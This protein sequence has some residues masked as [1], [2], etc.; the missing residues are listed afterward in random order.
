M[1]I[2]IYSG[3]VPGTTFIERLIKGLASKGQNVLLFGIKRRTVSYS[4]SVSVIGYKANRFSKSLHF[5]KY[6]LLLLLFK[7]KEKHIL[8]AL[9]RSQNRNTLN[10]KL[11][12]YPVLYHQ[13]D[14]FHVQWAKGLDD[15]MWVQDFGMKLVVSLRGAHINYSPIVDLELAAMYRQNFPKVDGFHAVSKTIG[16]EAQ[17]YRAAPEKIQV[18][19]SGLPKL[20]RNL[21]L[22]NFNKT[23]QLISV[24][25][26]HWIKGYS[27]ALDACKLLQTTG[28]SFKYTIIGG[29]DA[30]ELLYQV[31]D[32]GL[33]DVVNLVDNQ[34][35]KM[36]ECY[37]QD[38]DLLLLPSVE[39]GIANVVLEAMAI[40][41]LVLSTNCGGMSEVIVHNKNGF[42]IPIRDSKS[43][44]ETILHIASLSPETCLGI[45]EKAQETILEQHLEPHMVSGMLSLY[46][47]V[48]KG[49][50]RKGK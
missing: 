35:F 32:L 7:N 23:F 26:P 4:Q 28:F 21:S 27:Y 8:D 44:S 20:S 16:Q 3:E 46:E 38:A 14:V 45:R 11:K 15:W 24:G 50:T 37:M 48:V 31:Y 1:R 41:A 2:A 43:M 13:P 47:Q 30:M 6:N 22:R 40:G 29:T 36:V 10:E 5:L 18:V 17:I 34:P 9:L 39:E 33:Q 12:S 25:R 19:Y 42:L 49:N